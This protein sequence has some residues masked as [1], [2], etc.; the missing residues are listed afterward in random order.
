MATV[1]DG[2]EL[3][4]TGKAILDSSEEILTT[5]ERELR[6]TVKK[7][8]HLKHPII[9]DTIPAYL[10]VFAK[11][12]SPDYG[13]LGLEE[14]EVIA[15]EHG[16]ERARLTGYDASDLIQEY[17]IL[18][19]V[20]FSVLRRRGAMPSEHDAEIIH[21]LLDGTIRK[22]A[23]SFELVQMQIRE[24]FAATLTH[25]LRNPLGA[26]DMAAELILDE[27]ANPKEIVFLVAKLRENLKKANRMIQ[28]LLDTTLVKGGGRLPLKIEELDIMTVVRDVVR[29]QSLTHG[30]RFVIRGES[31]TGFWDPTAL[32][33]ALENLASNAIKYGDKTAEVTIEIKEVHERVIISVHNQGEPIPIHEQETIFQIYRRA[34]AAR[35]SGKQGWGLGLPLV[36]GVAESHGGSVGVASSAEGG[37]S[38]TLDIPRDARPYQNDPAFS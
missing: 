6:A 3:S 21:L 27:L 18:R 11:V 33:R 16:G 5:W 2:K 12:V 23:T 17:Q 4:P 15:D 22:A 8:T 30:R 10:D 34:H 20:I 19:R 37:T 13:I 28:D 25:D 24:Q 7:A 14:T 29:E 38:F 36:R 1:D 9:I 26:A 35:V 31:V 32:A